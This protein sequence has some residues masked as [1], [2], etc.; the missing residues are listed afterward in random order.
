MSKVIQCDLCGKLHDIEL[1][2]PPYVEVYYYVMSSH[3][4]TE[5]KDFCKDCFKKISDYIN[6]LKCLD[7]NINVSTESCSKIIKESSRKTIDT[8][9]CT[10]DKDGYLNKV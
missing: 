10:Y 2:D 8:S 9:K 1:T 5:H 3:D 6:S 7:L 4:R